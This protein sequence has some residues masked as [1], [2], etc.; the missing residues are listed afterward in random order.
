VLGAVATIRLFGVGRSTEKVT[1]AGPPRVVRNVVLERAPAVLA[2]GLGS[3]W[4]AEEPRVSL[5]GAEFQADERLLRLDPDTGLVIDG[6]PLAA[7]GSGSAMEVGEGAVWLGGLGTVSR[8]DPESGSQ[9]DAFGFGGG[10]TTIALA[11]EEPPDSPLRGVWVATPADDA[12]HHILPATGEIE[13]IASV[14]DRPLGVAVGEGAVWV[15]LAGEGAVGR[16]DAT[17][18][19][20]VERIKV[21][22]LTGPI[23]VGRGAVWAATGK[24]VARIDPTQNRVVGFVSLGSSPHTLAIGAGGVWAATDGGISVIYPT[25]NVASR[26]LDVTDVRGFAPVA[27]GMW[28]ATEQELLLLQAGAPASD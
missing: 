3:L 5:E 15:V 6:F 20:V 13:T 2:K 22:A 19:E 25:G 10:T 11:R 12:L 7:A 24:G 16:M 23:V 4:M 27:G 8:I 1:P 9:V 18:G 28:A 17:S 21:S 14:G 26:V